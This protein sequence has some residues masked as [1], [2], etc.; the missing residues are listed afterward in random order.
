M[1]FGE[2]LD[3]NFLLPHFKFRIPWGADYNWITAQQSRCA[4]PH[5]I[6]AFLKYG[7]MPEHAAMH[8]AP[9]AGSSTVV[10]ISIWIILCGILWS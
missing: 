3:P 4:C 1:A 2:F 6:L 9:V 10:T 8:R 7:Y 5:D